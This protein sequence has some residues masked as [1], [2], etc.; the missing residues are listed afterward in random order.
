MAAFGTA[1]ARWFQAP[2]RVNLIGEH[3]DY[4]DG[5]VLPCAID[6]QT[7]VAWGP[8]NDAE[9]DVVAADAGGRDRFA[10][11]SPIAHAD[12]EWANYIRGVA[13]ELMK[14]GHAV[15][16]A[17]LA[18]AGD[19][20]LGAGLSSSASLEVAVALALTGGALDGVEAALLCQRAE[21]LFVGCNC[22]IM[23]QLVSAAGAAGHALLIDC[24]SLERRLIP[25]PSDCALV[26]VDSGIRH[27]NIDGGYNSRRA[28]CDRA[29]RHYGVAALRDL[30][31][32]ILEDRRAGLDS[33][34]YARA[35]HVVTENARVLAAADA[36][37]AGDLAVVGALMAA[38]HRSMRDDFQITV[39]AIDRIVETIDDV[40]DG[41][42]GARMTGGGFGGSV[43]ALAPADL[44]DA[45]RG[46]L[47]NE[48]VLRGDARASVFTASAGAGEMPG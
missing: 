14:A 41:R 46:R 32:A 25:L 1:P 19:V 35:R 29:V 43:V 39:P 4:N 45:L 23:D 38:S 18:I 28:E 6:R 30:D 34:T 42:G 21:N 44:V 37:A 7:A 27:A 5:F 24:R 15:V 22:G 40:L 16:P 9:I 47:E 11:V 36:L 26:V 12:A 2:G 8:A 20:P 31:E 17:R 33:A 48:A 10:P 13:D 3:T